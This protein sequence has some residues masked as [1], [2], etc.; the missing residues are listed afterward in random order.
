[1]KKVVVLEPGYKSYS[2]ETEI[3]KQCGAELVVIP[4][5]VENKSLPGLLY[6]ASIIMLRD[7]KLDSTI[8][9][10][11]PELKGIVRYGVGYDN[12]DCDYA[13]Q[14][15]IIVSNVPDYGSDAVAE[16]ALGLMLA[17]SRQICLRDKEVRLGAWNIAENAP[18]RLMCGKTLGLVSFGRIA[19]AFLE[20]ARGLGFTRVLIHDPNITK[21]TCEKY[22][23]VSVDMDFLCK[24][25]D[26]ISL[27][28]PLNEQTRHIINKDRINIM[29][30]SC[31]LVNTGRGGLIDENALYH[32]LAERRIHSAAIDVYEN[33]PAKNGHPFF[34]LSN[35]IVSDHTA[36]YSVESC[37][38]LQSKAAE[39]V[40]RILHGDK[41][42]NWVN[43]WSNK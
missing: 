16:Y 28:A 24:E 39:E 4:E 14:K 18:M 9:D 6:D 35:C 32:A 21:E 5:N 37:H 29:K 26:F 13:K 33:E 34:A 22:N 2:A 27:H 19:R 30:K 1:M 15:K 31:V 8:I 38:E 23:V 25:S 36:W 17:S 7:R 12:V 20:K 41:P 42:K 11:A 43:Q 3:L 40:V 10:M